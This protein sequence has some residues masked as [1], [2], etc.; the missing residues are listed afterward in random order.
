MDQTGSTPW[1]TYK[2]GNTIY[3]SPQKLRQRECHVPVLSICIY[4]RW[5]LGPQSMQ[6]SYP[7]KSILEC[8]IIAKCSLQVLCAVHVISQEH[9]HL[10]PQQS[11]YWAWHTPCQLQKLATYNSKQNPMQWAHLSQRS[12]HHETVA[13]QN[14]RAG[15]YP[16]TTSG[17][18]ASHPGKSPAPSV[19][20]KMT[21][22]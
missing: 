11:P 5:C 7:H 22:I 4:K 9:S 13:L 16:E 12:D 15:C 14:A 8:K 17:W 1:T 2:A 19:P 3:S 21:W 20:T 10:R 6:R 18:L